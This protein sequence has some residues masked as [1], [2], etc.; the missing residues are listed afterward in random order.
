MFDE[1]HQEIKYYLRKSIFVVAGIATSV[2]AG[3]LASKLFTTSKEVQALTSEV[4][5]LKEDL[6]D[7]ERRVSGLGG[8]ISRV[9]HHR[10]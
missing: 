10:R 9:A 2:A 4:K 3:H 8:R 7:L 6:R 5:E 1:Y